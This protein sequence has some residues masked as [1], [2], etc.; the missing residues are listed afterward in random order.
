[1]AGT[2]SNGVSN[3]GFTATV[4]R[5]DKRAARKQE[6]E[7]L[8]RVRNYLRTHNEVTV[9]INGVPTTL[10]DKEMKSLEKYVSVKALQPREIP[11]YADMAIASAT[12]FM[13]SIMVGTLVSAGASPLAYASTVLLFAPINWAVAVTFNRRRFLKD[14]DPKYQEQV[15][16]LKS[17]L[18]NE[19][20]NASS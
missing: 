19:A 15:N 11:L 20:N 4:S 17:K 6:K 7:E 9:E 2:K 8:K 5:S 12:L 1:M 3:D 18:R 14:N 13:D 10:S 16:S